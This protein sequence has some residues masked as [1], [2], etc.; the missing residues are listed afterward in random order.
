MQGDTQFNTQ[1][2]QGNTNQQITSPNLIIERERI[3]TEIKLNT[4]LYISLSDQL[5]LAKID[6][7]DNTSSLFLLDLPNVKTKKTGMSLIEGYIL[8]FFISSIFYTISII[9]RD[10]KK[11]FN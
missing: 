1:K 2:V 5:A 3:N 7:N 10:R 4:Q 9:Y 6:A 8:M 11:L